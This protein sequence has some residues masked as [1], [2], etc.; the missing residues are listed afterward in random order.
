MRQE[1]NL[2]KNVESVGTW[3]LPKIRAL[4]IQ[5]M[6]K[7]RLKISNLVKRFDFEVVLYVN[8]LNY[9]GLT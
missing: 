7:K 9:F 5:I 2:T 8:N 3:Y 1:G 4:K 6:A